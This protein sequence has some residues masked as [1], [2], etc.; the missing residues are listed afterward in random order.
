[1]ETESRL[2]VARTCQDLEGSVKLLFN[3]YRVS[4]CDFVEMDG[5]EG[6]STM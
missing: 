4:V 3:E 6:G 5:G 1:M 2:V